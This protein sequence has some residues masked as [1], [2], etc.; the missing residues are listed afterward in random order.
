MDKEYIERKIKNCKELILHANSKAQAEIYQGYLDYWKS[1]Y[2]PKPKKQTTKKPD[3]KEAV[4]AFK[5]EFPTK[6]SHYKRDNK[7]YRTKAFKEFLKSYK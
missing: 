1:S 3:I 7:K 6:K 2:I 5:L 4:K